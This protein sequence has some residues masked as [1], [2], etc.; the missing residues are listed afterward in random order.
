MTILQI[1][2]IFV[3]FCVVWIATNAINAAIIAKMQ[4]EQQRRRIDA[5]FGQITRLVLR[6]RAEAAARRRAADD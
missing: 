6:A 1:I 3:I 4:Q 2:T 5:A